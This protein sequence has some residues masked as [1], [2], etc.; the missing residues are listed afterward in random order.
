MLIM[1]LIYTL[2]KLFKSTYSLEKS[3]VFKL[4]LKIK[5]IIPFFLI[6]SSSFNNAVTEV[7]RISFS[8]IK[9]ESSIG[10]IDVEKS[11]LDKTTI[12]TINSEVNTRV[13]FNFNAVGREKSIYNEDTLVFS[14]VYRKINKKV[15]L[16]QS[17]SLIEGKYFLKNKR[18]KEFLDIGVINNNLVT[19]FFIEPVYTKEVY[20][21]KYK[22]MVKITP[23]ERGKYQVILPNK[24]SNIYYYKNGACAKVEVVGTFYKVKLIPNNVI[25]N[26]L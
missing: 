26:T 19:L 15:K 1:L 8:V 21:D 16:N 12:Y 22:K 23:L 6:S 3:T 7:E 4:V 24:S 20:L 11:S 18:K 10:F 13:I 9:N 14:S 17:L 5:Y 25:E 2:K